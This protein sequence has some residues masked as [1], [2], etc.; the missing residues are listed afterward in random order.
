MRGFPS[1]GALLCLGSVPKPRPR[2]VVSPSPQV[3]G[4][5]AWLGGGVLQLGMVQS[6]AFLQVEVVPCC[7]L[8]WCRCQVNHSGNLFLPPPR[9]NTPLFS[10]SPVTHYKQDTKDYF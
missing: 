1:S 6:G 3:D 8:V 5:V 10:H 4:P 9:G 2:G 7:C